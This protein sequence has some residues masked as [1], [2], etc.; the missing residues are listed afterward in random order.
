MTTRRASS[1]LAVVLSLASGLW[2]QE[3]K[4]P[5]KEGTVKFALIGDTGTGSRAQTEVG[6]QMA[7]F[8]K[9][10]PF[11]FVVM[12]GDNMYGS[13]GPR[14]FVSKFEAPYKELLAANVKFFAALGNHDEPGQRNYKHFN[15]AGERFYAFRAT[16][17]EVGT[18][19]DKGD[20][21]YALD[22]N[23]MDKS[24]LDWIEK[25]LSA[26]DTEW[27]IC[28]FHHPLYSSAR[29]HG[30]ALDLRKVLEPLFVQYKV[31]LVL[32]GHEHVYERVKPQQG[33]Y[34]FVSGA[35]GTLRKGDLR[36][37]Q[38]TAAGFD[39]DYHFMLF[40]IDGN[41]MHFQAISRTGS[42]VDSGTLKK[43]E[44][45]KPEELKPAS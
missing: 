13:Q 27:K 37:G 36:P 41:E 9:R 8:H 17:T 2:A 14:D 35:G 30:S 28:F 31:N 25:Q 26:G 23:Y 24:Q 38:Y 4:V 16:P 42:T 22:S 19:V 44:E 32:A 40:E 33:I 12:V 5:N 7:A 39:R 43:Q 11:T 20:R 6:A 18:K 45:K 34:Y 3:L 1:A 21:F 10:F 29:K 15:M